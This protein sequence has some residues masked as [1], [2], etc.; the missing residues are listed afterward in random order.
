[1]L[2]RRGFTLIELLAVI[3]I[4]GV[5]VALLLP[6]V[7]SAREAARRTHCIN[8]LKQMGLALNGYHDGLG[9]FPSSYLARA[10]FTDGATDTA[11]GWGWG[12]MLLPYLE[13]PA[14]YHAANFGQPVE[15][16]MN[17]TAVQSMLSAYL[18]PSDATPD[19]PFTVTDS[20]ANPL[21]ALA[22]SSY[23]ACVGGDESDTTTGI[24]NDGL[25]KGVM[26][27]NSAVRMADI[28]DGA[29]NT[30]A[31]G[32][33]AWSINRG[34]WAGVV[35]NGV[36]GRGPDNPCPTTGAT[37]YPAAT[38]VQVHCNVLNSITDPDGGLDDFSSRHP[39]GANVTFADGSVHFFRSVLGNSGRR[40]DG[41]T[42]YS[43][44]SLRL[45]AYGTRNG[46]EVV[47]DPA[48]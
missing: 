17:A 12:T 10:R 27:R 36:I 30:I 21:A 26:F 40:S 41:T 11:P 34:P 6:A 38:L 16:T 32:E 14:L 44:G 22:P 4:I 19:G 25:G 33:R 48:Y 18:C 45:Q 37:F 5:L 23:A 9:S 1:M 39:G 7:Q 46:R 3:A 13:Q 15:A 24:N 20:G 47:S 31:V 28:I 2:R 35:T 42:I 29:S 43:P 8:N